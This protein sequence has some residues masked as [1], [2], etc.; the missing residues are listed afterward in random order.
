M[1]WAT[2]NIGTRSLSA[3]IEH[4]DL[5]LVGVYVHSAEKAGRDAGDLCERAATGV[6][7]TNDVEEILR[8]GADCVLYM[9]AACDFDEVRRI[10][11]AGS[12][13]VT[14]RGEFLRPASMDASHRAEIEAACEMGRASIHST[15]SSPGFITEAVP[16]VLSSL[17]RRV[18]RIVISEFADLSQRN[19]PELLFG[20]MGFGQPPGEVDQRRAAHLA[21]SF[22]PS[23]ELVA[24]AISLPLDEVTASG[25]VA[26]ARQ[27]T[28]IAAGTLEQGTVAAQRT[29]VSGVRA[30]KPLIEFRATWYCTSDLEQDWKLRSTGWTISVA[31]DAPLDADITFTTP[32][33]EMAAVTPG[34]TAHRAVNAVPF[35]CAAEPGIRTSLDLPQIV[36]TLR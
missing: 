16:L 31:G 29:T 28:V 20:L 4:P 18:D 33:Q 8:L 25:D 22:G 13:V 21:A 19:S 15:G 9:P 12:N 11:S 5:E 10:L 3:V 17:Q 7:A 2:G 34:Y 35:V 24:E 14:T 23:L 36:P 30:G 26:T 32:V 27:R 6:L 1:Q